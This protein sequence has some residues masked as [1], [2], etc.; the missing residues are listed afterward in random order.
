MSHRQLNYDKDLSKEY[1]MFVQANQENNPT[2]TNVARMIKAVYLRPLDNVQEGHELT[3]VDP[4]KVITRRKMTEILS[5]ELMIKAV[6][7]LAKR[8][9]VKS[10]KFENK[11]GV[12]FPDINF[13]G[14]NNEASEA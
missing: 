4:R 2:N 9:K 3:N 10:L 5:A 1:G 14:K 6:E 13:D 12:S 11:T 8:D 7:E